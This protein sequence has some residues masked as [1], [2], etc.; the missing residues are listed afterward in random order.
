MW[1]SPGWEGTREISHYFLFTVIG[2]IP[3]IRPKTLPFLYLKEQVPLEFLRL[4]F[5]IIICAAINVVRLC[6]FTSASRDVSC[7]AP[8]PYLQF[9]AGKEL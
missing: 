5:L 6:Y 8:I 7:L 2:K 4:V 1:L 9:S 3:L